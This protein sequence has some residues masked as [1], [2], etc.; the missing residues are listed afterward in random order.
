[1]V[2]DRPGLLPVAMES[3]YYSGGKRGW[4]FEKQELGELPSWLSSNQP[5]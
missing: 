1:M 3:N 5:D 4:P 2:S